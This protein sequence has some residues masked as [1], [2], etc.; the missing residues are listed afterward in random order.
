M[1]RSA[2]SSSALECNSLDLPS[3]HAFSLPP[4]SASLAEKKPVSFKDLP[5]RPHTTGRQL[6]ETDQ[7]NATK[8]L[9]FKQPTIEDLGIFPSSCTPAACCLDVRSVDRCP[10]E[11]GLRGAGRSIRE[12]NQVHAWIDSE[13]KGDTLVSLLAVLC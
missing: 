13:I 9:D 4:C 5:L 6:E 10:I 2:Q 11:S 12:R 3:P 7:D 8:T 1:P